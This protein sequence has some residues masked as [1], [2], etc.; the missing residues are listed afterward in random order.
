[1]AMPW[2]DE[3]SRRRLSRSN[4]TVG[5]LS[6]EDLARSVRP[7]ILPLALL[8]GPLLLPQGEK[9]SPDDPKMCECRSPMGEELWRCIVLS[10]MFES[11]SSRKGRRV[12]FGI[13][14]DR[15][16]VTFG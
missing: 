1:M 15:A 6:R 7:L 16:C 12:W 10:H 13:V 14:L 4:C 3:G 5:G 11:G 9:G 2:E 8:A